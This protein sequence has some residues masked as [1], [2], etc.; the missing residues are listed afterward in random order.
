VNVVSS[1]ADSKKDEILVPEIV[2]VSPEEKKTCPPVRKSSI[3]L[4]PLSGILVLFLDYAFFAGEIPIV[5]IPIACLLAFIITFTG[6]FLIQRNLE[7]ESNRRSFA[8]AFFG[9]VITAIPT[10]VSG[11][12]FGT[13]ILTVS[14]LNYIGRKLFGQ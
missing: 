14:G 5:S 3:N 13:L 8:K 4:H 7:E 9:A 10:P 6:V 2:N 1:P 11:T 12:I